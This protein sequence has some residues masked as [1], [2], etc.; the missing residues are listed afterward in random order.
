MYTLLFTFVVIIEIPRMR[1]VYAYCGETAAGVPQRHCLFV[2][3]NPVFEGE[4]QGTRLDI[5]KIKN[6]FIIS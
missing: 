3:Q 6:I 2:G 5:K 1:N 4:V